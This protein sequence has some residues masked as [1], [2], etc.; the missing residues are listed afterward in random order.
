MMICVCSNGMQLTREQ[1]DA[2]NSI[3]EKVKG[4]FNELAEAITNVFRVLRDRIYWSKIRPLLHI[5]PKS[6]RQRK[7]QQR[8]IERILV[9]QVLDRR[10]KINMIK[11]RISYAE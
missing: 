7:K 9:S 3:V 5:K 2:I 8:K 4:Y 11:Q 1:I 10:K 6:K